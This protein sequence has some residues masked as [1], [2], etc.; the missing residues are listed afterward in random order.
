MNN[1]RMPEKTR[2]AIIDIRMSSVAKHQIL[3][4][5]IEH[6]CR[7]T[8]TYMNVDSYTYLVIYFVIANLQ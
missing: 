1:E 2:I 4:E 3:V 5:T 6:T 8:N 7:W